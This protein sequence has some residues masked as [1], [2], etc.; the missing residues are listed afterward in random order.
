MY[1]LYTSNNKTP[2]TMNKKMTPIKLL[3]TVKNDIFT[4]MRGQNAELDKVFRNAS[5]RKANKN[6]YNKFT[7]T[8][9]SNSKNGDVFASCSYKYIA[10]E[11]T[12]N[13][14]SLVIADD[15]DIDNML[16]NS[17]KFDANINYDFDSDNVKN[18]S[19]N[20][21]DHI[22]KNMPCPTIDDSGFYVD[23]MNWK[24]LVRNIIKH[25]N[26]MLIGP[27]GTGK[28]ELV[29]EIAK[30][31]NL[32][33]SIYD[34]GAMQDPLTDLLGTHRL[35]GNSSVFDYAQFVE[36]VQKPGIILLD[37]LSRA[38]QMAMNILFP[39]LDSRRELRID[40]AGSNNIRKVKVHPECVFIA[41][42]NIG[43]E[44]SGTQDIDVALLNRFLPLQLDYMPS[45]IEEH[46]LIVRTEIDENSAKTICNYAKQ[47]RESYK[48]EVLSKSISTRETLAIAELVVDGF[49]I[50][51]AFKYIIFQKFMSEDEITTMKS[52]L[53]SM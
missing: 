38:P 1:Y 2:K 18:M 12:F 32:N 28:T 47:I 45:K 19:S 52:I 29:M 39:C 50:Q 31:L 26:T 27:T 10:E 49:T 20:I 48:N 5:V 53:I 9:L 3:F 7:D 24:F 44:Y 51:D 43:A 46:V 41:T 11:H 30:K 17:E 34:M 42:A 23:N 25:K 40:I 4:P 37:E 6:N 14:Y 13:F 15:T 8:V 21:M 33:I 22:S 36:D 16:A 35:E